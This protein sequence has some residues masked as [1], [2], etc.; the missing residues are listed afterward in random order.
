MEDQLLGFALVPLL[1]IAGKGKVTADFSLSST[2]LFHSPAGT[3][4]LSLSLDAT[5]LPVDPLPVKSSITSEVVLLDRKIT[6]VDL[7]PVEYSRI[8]F[9]DINVVAENQQMVSEYFTASSKDDPIGIASFLH[10]GSCPISQH[11]LF[12][13]GILGNYSG[14]GSSA[15]SGGSVQNSRFLSST[16]TSI[17]EDGNSFDSI[18]NKG[19]L[20]SQETISS[21]NPEANQCSVSRCPH[22]LTSKEMN[23]AGEEQRSRNTSERNPT[24]GKIGP[25]STNSFEQVSSANLEADQSAMQQ[26][27]MGMYMRSMQQFTESLAKMKLPMDLDGLEH[28]QKSDLE[29]RKNDGSRV[30][31][32]SR[33]F[34]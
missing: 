6:E 24:D 16:I 18:K 28:Q 29:Q 30:F 3:V 19:H 17:S 9:P 5:S 20:P 1:E 26:Q 11:P 34:F 15:S 27:I 12:E 8:E 2:D 14:N 25:A 21:M 22:T 4:R 7:G 23:E 13:Y 31:Y 10:L 33:A 32:G